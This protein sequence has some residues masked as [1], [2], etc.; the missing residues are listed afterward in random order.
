MTNALLPQ[1]RRRLFVLTVASC[2]TAWFMFGLLLGD[3]LRAGGAG[4]RPSRVVIAT[5]AACAVLA[6]GS[7]VELLRLAPRPTQPV[8][9]GVAA[10]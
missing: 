9:T 3:V 4:Q 7:I 6:V 8:G 2:A 10:T 1:G 5:V